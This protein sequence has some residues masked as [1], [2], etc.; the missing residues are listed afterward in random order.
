L[1][2]RGLARGE[3][4]ARGSMASRTSV[5]STISSIVNFRWSIH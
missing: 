4:A 2:V 5:K 1:H 3:A